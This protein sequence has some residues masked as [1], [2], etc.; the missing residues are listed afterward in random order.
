LTEMSLLPHTG[1]S[2]CTS[3]DVS[4]HN[5]FIMKSLLSTDI[6]VLFRH[7]DG[8]L[9]VCV[10]VCVCVRVCLCVCVCVG[11]GVGGYCQPDARCSE[12]NGASRSGPAQ[13]LPSVPAHERMN[14]RAAAGGW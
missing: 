6:F 3:R 5:S 7:I 10:C 2:Y 14:A 8:V 1:C 13:P 12:P 9:C 4:Q 11:W